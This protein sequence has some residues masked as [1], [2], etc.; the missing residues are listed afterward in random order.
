MSSPTLSS[1]HRLLFAVANWQTAAPARVAAHCIRLALLLAVFSLLALPVAHAQASV[2]GNVT[3]APIINTLAGDGTAGYGG[4]GSSATSAELNN[5]ADTAVDNAGNIYIADA[6][7]D[8]VRKVTAATGIITTVA[9]TGTAGYNGDGILATSAELDFPTG[10]A[11]DNAGNL[12]IADENNQ[13][14]RKVTVS[15]GDIST[16]AGNGTAGY[17]GDGILATSAELSAP[18]GVAV[19]NAGNLYIADENN[20]RIRKVTVSTG[21]ISTVAGDGTTGYN[22][23][24]ILATSAEL[25][26]PQGVAVDSASNLYI[27]DSNNSRI[28]KVTVSTGDISTIAGDGTFGYGGDGGSATSA[29]L[30]TPTG[31]VVDNAGNL[32]IADENNQRIRKVTASTGDISTVVGDGSNGYI[33]NG[34]LATN[35]ELDN[36]EG[37][38]VDGSDN[39]YIADTFNQRIRKASVDATLPTTVV[40]TTSI[41]QDIF[42]QLTA[43]SAISSI[44]VPKAQNNVQEFTV[45]TVTGCATDGTTSNASGAVCTVPITFNPQ[46]PGPRMGALTVN[47]GSTVVGTAGLYGTGQGPKVVQL[48]GGLDAVA[49]GGTSPA[50]AVTTTPEPALGAALTLSSLVV[51]ED[52]NLY[53]ADFNN[54][55]VYKVTMAT[56]QIV[57][58]AGNDTYSGGSV[59]STTP[60][61]ALGADITPSDAIV[62]GADNLY[63]ADNSN[64]LIERVD[65]TTQEIVVVAGGGSVKPTTTPEAASSAKLAYPQGIALDGAG[66][67]YIADQGHHVVEKLTGLSTASPQIVVVAGTDSN[68]GT[69]SSTTPAAATSVAINPYGLALDSAGN[70]YIADQGCAGTHYQIDKLNP[71]GQ[72]VVVAGD[73]S[74][75]PSTT[76]EPATSA[77]LSL[78]YDVAVDGAGNLY[79]PDYGNML[80]EKVDA[81]TQEIVVVAGG[82]TTPSSTTLIPATSA[83]LGDT[84]AV[85]VDGAGNFYIADYTNSLVDKVSAA[86]LPLNFPNTYVGASSTPQTVTIA[87]IGNQALDILSLSDAVD[88]PLGSASTCTATATSGQTLDVGSSCDLTYT[89]QP[90]T[91]G[92]LSE[93]ST[94][95]D[96]TPSGASTQQA[97]PF[98]GT[99]LRYA[100][101]T[102]LLAAPSP[103]TYGQSVM[104]TATVTSSGGTPGGTVTFYNGSTS[105]GTGTLNSSGAATLAT[106]ALPVGGNSLTASYGVTAKYAASTS[107]ATT[108]T[109]TAATTTTTLS[110]SPTSASY[111]Q[112]VTLTATVT[113]SG[114]TPTGTV[115][116]YDGS[117]SLGTGTLNSSGVATLLATTSLPVGSDSVT[118]GYNA[119]TDYAAS[120]SSAVTLTMIPPSYMVTANPSSLSI[121]QGQTGYVTLTI[122]P[123]GDYLGALTLNCTNLPT[124]TRCVFTQNGAINNVATLSGNGQTMTVE[125]AIQTGS[126]TL[127][128]LQAP[129]A[130]WT[131]AS[132]VNP[133]GPPS[134]M[135]P[136]LTFW[137]PGSVAGLAALERKRRASKISQKILHLCLLGL[138]TGALAA[139]ISGCGSGANLSNV[140]P[141]GTSTM[142]VQAIPTAGNGQ[143]SQSLSL[144]LSITITQ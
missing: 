116:F 126:V 102:T 111:G 28:R 12:Y 57:V 108:A 31:V 90:T 3:L 122:T 106:T 5:P 88:F 65:A 56:G 140:T 79:I 59:P 18:R 73:G 50:T 51:S 71:A 42:V 77:K 86:V 35:A 16:V 143:S 120:V 24:G 64:S 58:V 89:F 94:L 109:V 80:L 38:A 23:D 6:F 30:S 13:R 26:D 97:I 39:L 127:A 62:D 34:G 125:L 53:I 135:L 96:N 98:L 40:G 33:G 139:G 8:A 22:G 128:Q 113:S 87:N 4:D 48:P 133:Q 95:T 104:L 29:E 99:G 66:N 92:T 25:N 105:L 44:T 91:G 131:G 117:T 84:Q 20:Q 138:M 19:D 63:I 70:L 137:W 52:G 144:S 101:A 85:A 123:V 107:T 69:F 60:E 124:N 93:S 75:V 54:C 119:T 61:P 82:G 110:A 55:L 132:P 45:G 129:P 136:A 115:T 1:H 68:A 103:S 17:N 72:I 37:V 43:T 83:K 112:S 134:P 9:G 2:S 114:G 118:A 141:F 41:S 27:A 100:T 32:Y 36:P 49:G 130:I 15:T 10:V 11:V 76:P 46:Y 74:T 47:N 78:P 21:D 67:M 81:A 142:T 121:V 7:N 14:I